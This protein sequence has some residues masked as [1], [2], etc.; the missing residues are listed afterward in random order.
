MILGS[1]SFLFL[2]PVDF[3]Q[4]EPQPHSICSLMPMVARDKYESVHGLENSRQHILFFC[5]TAGSTPDRWKRNC[6]FAQK[7][8]RPDLCEM[9]P[10]CMSLRTRT[11]SRATASCMM[12]PRIP[13]HHYLAQPAFRGVILESA[14][15]AR[16]G[17]DP[18]GVAQLHDT[19]HVSNYVSYFFARILV[20]RMR[21]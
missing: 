9:V 14:D 12:D 6:A 8:F 11:G 1:S 13:V 18:V 15:P 10:R 17:T 5:W 7:D 19:E 20:T 3:F 4:A 2:C 16:T 21:R